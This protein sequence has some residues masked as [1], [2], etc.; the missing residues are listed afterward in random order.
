LFGHVSHFVARFRMFECEAGQRRE[1][2]RPM[3]R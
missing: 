2:D 1:L 3:A